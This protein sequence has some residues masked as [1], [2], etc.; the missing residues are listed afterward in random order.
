MSNYTSYTYLS[1]IAASILGVT[2]YSGA[3]SGACSWVSQKYH[4]LRSLVTL[5]N[6]M[7]PIESSSNSKEP[8]FSVNPSDLSACISYETMH[9]KYSINIPYN[10]E[11][12]VAMSQFKAE[13]L[14]RDLD[15]LDITQQP[16]IPYMLTATDLGGFAIRITNQEID[17]SHVY[18]ENTIPG[19]GVEVM[20]GE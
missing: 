6:N 1:L 10:R 2:Y 17:R 18:D 8:A 19:Y 9:K 4:T 20:D 16:G 11:N 13:L 12:I 7:K 14:R 3:C 15:A 5:M